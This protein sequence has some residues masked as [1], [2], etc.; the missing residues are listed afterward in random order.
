MQTLEQTAFEV[1]EEQPETRCC[2]S[3]PIISFNLMSS[4]G[5][6]WRTRTELCPGW[7]RLE[8]GSS[9]TRAFA[10]SP[11]TG[12][13]PLPIRLKVVPASRVLSA[14]SPRSSASS[15][16]SCG[17]SIYFVVDLGIEPISVSSRQ[18]LNERGN[19]ECL[20]HSNWTICSMCSPSCFSYWEANSYYP[21]GLIMGK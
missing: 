12:K 19:F 21:R 16:S 7:R 3:W 9:S 20:G 8:S 6:E 11:S 18:D 4:F 1:R 15:P 14:T 2:F 10:P 17:P 13:T 5:E